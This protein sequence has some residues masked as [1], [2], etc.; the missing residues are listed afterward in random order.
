[1]VLAST[2]G[3]H[4]KNATHDQCASFSNS[5]FSPQANALV[6]SWADNWGSQYVVTANKWYGSSSVATIHG[7]GPNYLYVEDGAGT[8]A[9]GQGSAG[10]FKKI[11]WTWDATHTNFYMCT[12]AYGHTTLDAVVLASTEGIHLKNATHDQCASFSNSIFSPQMLSIEGS[13][14]DNYG[15]YYI[16]NTSS[17]YSGQTIADRATSFVLGYGPS[18]A[19]VEQGPGTWSVSQGSPGVFQKIEWTWDANHTNFYMCTTAYG[20]TTLDAVVLASTEGIH[21]K[22]AT[23]DKCSGFSNSIYSPVEQAS[24]L[25]Y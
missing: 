4:L 23:H 5:I 8:W 2:E 24:N 12:T 6:G 19:Y 25:L 17:Y 20:H 21:L 1:V 16:I 11:E 7:V 22:N 18:Y 3:I 13:W 9:V 14:A 10:V 15:N